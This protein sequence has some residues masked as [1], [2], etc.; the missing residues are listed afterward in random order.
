MLSRVAVIAGM[1]LAGLPG[2]ASADLIGLYDPADTYYNGVSAIPQ[3][4]YT[5][6]EALN[7]ESVTGLA[8]NYDPGPG[9][10]DSFFWSLWDS[11]ANG[12]LG[13]QLLHF[14]GTSPTLDPGFGTYETP[15]NLT[16]QAGH[17]YVVAFQANNDPN[18]VPYGF[19]TTPYTTPGGGFEVVSG[20][21]SAVISV[22][23]PLY[24]TT[25][26]SLDLGPNAAVPEPSTLILFGIGLSAG[27][28]CA[29]Q[30][31]IRRP[32]I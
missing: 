10:S 22:N 30:R 14:Q 15:V 29:W 19:A 31:K 7:D 28:A 23:D 3:T 17:Y 12:A 26:M 18:N 13:T 27:V 11:N 8:I 16:F 9:N 21:A 5:L 1:L 24:V 20:G 32:A 6:F 2:G 25:E 4:Y